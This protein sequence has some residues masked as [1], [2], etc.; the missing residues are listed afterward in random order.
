MLGKL[1][2]PLAKMS[3]PEVNDGAVS[4]PRSCL[5][6]SG[7]PDGGST[8]HLPPEE[9]GL[10]GAVSQQRRG[11]LWGGLTEDLLLPSLRSV[12]LDGA[13]IGVCGR[14][15]KSPG[16]QAS[17]VGEGRRALAGQDPE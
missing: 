7:R 1:T 14:S 10:P 15:S 8:P 12:R 17:E 9:E 13:D 16:F 5:S 3:V 2:V 11:S 6:R 4:Q